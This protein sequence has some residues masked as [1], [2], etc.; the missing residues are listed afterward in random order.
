[1]KTVSFTEFRKNASE[2]ITKVEKGEIIHILRHGKPVAE[3]T[4]LQSEELSTPSWKKPALKLSLNG[5]SL[6]QAIIEER[7]SG[8]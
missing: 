3:I 1:M 6:S 8:T 7:R 2:L 5:I 4:P